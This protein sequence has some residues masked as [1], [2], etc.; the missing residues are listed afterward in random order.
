MP[1]AVTTIEKNGN[2]IDSIM[3]EEILLITHQ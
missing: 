3:E 1:D 2:I